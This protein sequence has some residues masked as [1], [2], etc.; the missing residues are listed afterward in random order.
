VSRLMFL[1]G[2]NML[3]NFYV[4]FMER[5][6]GIATERE[7]F[8]IP[9]TS[10]TVALLTLIA[11]IPSAR[12][13]DRI[14][15]KPVIYAACV[16]GALGMAIA[17]VAPSIEVFVLGVVG[18]GVASGTFLAVDWALMTDIIPKAASGRYMGISNIAVVA[19]GPFASLIGGA[20]I[21]V[22][23]G[24][25]RS[26]VGPRA[27]FGAAIALFLMAAF[28]LRRV[29]A[30]PHSGTLPDEVAVTAA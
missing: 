12:L 23:G 4:W 2:I 27:A 8:L 28:F 10:G 29:D 6:L 17:A 16:I 26:G 25:I 7:G 19:G 5:S 15:R 20:L 13:S 11:T 1:A 3:L 9:V 22:F 14:G 21:F 24:D 18:I 30:T